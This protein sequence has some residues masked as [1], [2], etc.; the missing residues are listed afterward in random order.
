MRSAGKCGSGN[1]KYSICG[2]RSTKIL[3]FFRS[4]TFYSTYTYISFLLLFMVRPLFW[5]PE[6]TRYMS[7]LCSMQAHWSFKASENAGFSLRKWRWSRTSHREGIV[8]SCCQS[9][10]FE[11]HPQNHTFMLKWSFGSME[12]S[13]SASSCASLTVR[14]GGVLQL[15]VTMAPSII[16]HCQHTW[17]ST[18]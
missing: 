12:E 6:T 9:A 10:P 2:P 14:F 1:G 4:L 3:R 15:H 8:F 13:R 5:H 16:F 18:A 7:K 11:A 17:T